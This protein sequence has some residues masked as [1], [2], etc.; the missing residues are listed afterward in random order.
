M[1]QSQDRMA[2]WLALECGC[3]RDDA[4]CVAAHFID[5]YKDV[6]KRDKFP[7]DSETQ[8]RRMIMSFAAGYMAGRK[9]G[10]KTKT[11]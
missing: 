7:L 4:Q 3:K 5:F 6:F 1:D 2:Q 9:D 10:K 11:K 8:A